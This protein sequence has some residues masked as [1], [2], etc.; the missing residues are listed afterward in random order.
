MCNRSTKSGACNMHYEMDSRNTATSAHYPYYD[1]CNKNRTT[2]EQNP[3]HK[4]GS[5]DT[6]TGEI[7]PYS[8]QISME[9]EEKNTITREIYKTTKIDYTYHMAIMRWIIPFQVLL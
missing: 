3:C 6:A 7:N 5:K 1:M 9:K 2:C 4:T 8:E